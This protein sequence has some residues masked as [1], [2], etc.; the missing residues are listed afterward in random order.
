MAPGYC[1]GLIADGLAV[2]KPG[3][4]FLVWRHFHWL[5]S[6]SWVPALGYRSAGMTRDESRAALCLTR[7]RLQSPHEAADR[8]VL[9]G[10]CDGPVIERLGKGGE[11]PG[12]D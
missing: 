12:D 3:V 8:R 6:P 4:P 11:T 7:A 1:W 10:V 2:R 9:A 5:S